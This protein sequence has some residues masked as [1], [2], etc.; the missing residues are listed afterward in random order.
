MAQE[1]LAYTSGLTGATITFGDTS[2]PTVFYKGIK[3]AGM[4]PVDNFVVDTAYQPGAQFV[5]TKKKSTVLIATLS[6]FGDPNAAD[7]RASL[8]STIDT[9][10]AVLEPSISTPGTLV[11]TDSQGVQRLL[12]NVQYVGGHE[13][14]DQAANRAYITL[15]LVFEAYDPTWYSSA[16]HSQQIGASTDPFGFTVPITVPLVINGQAQGTATITNAGNIHSHPIFTFSGPCQNFSV[17]NAT[18]QEGFA[19]TQQLFAGDTIV[20]DCNLGTVTYTPSGGASG[21]LYSAF[22]GARQWM[23]LAPGNNNVS[24]YRDVAAS[25]QCSIA[26]YDTSNHG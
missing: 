11:K 2:L 3:G 12:K 13:M 10:L 4:A 8:W 14:D 5:R 17:Y 24:F 1:T 20:V 9:I 23:R 7:A 16:Q 26:W 22:A 19:I 21:P 25:Q 6:V 15:D 18:T